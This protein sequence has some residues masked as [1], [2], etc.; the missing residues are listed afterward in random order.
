MCVLLDVDDASQIASKINLEDL[1]NILTVQY[2]NEVI[3]LLIT[4]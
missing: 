3:E 2:L 4:S 1:K